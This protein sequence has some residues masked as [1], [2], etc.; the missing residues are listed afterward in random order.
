MV[1][2]LVVFCFV[3][4]IRRFRVC[5]CVGFLLVSPARSI[6]ASFFFPTC[7]TSENSLLILRVVEM[8][9]LNRREL[10]ILLLGL[11]WSRNH[12][13]WQLLGHPNLLVSS[14]RSPAI[15]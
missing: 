4:H 1:K 3:L 12:F 9:V 6:V 5:V 15:A 13:V 10:P 8:V 2:S 11:K 7:L 14:V